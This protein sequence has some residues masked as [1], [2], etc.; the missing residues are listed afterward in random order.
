MT[1]PPTQD[2]LDAQFRA[3]IAS[4][5]ELAAWMALLQLEERAG[6]TLAL[7]RATFHRLV[8]RACQ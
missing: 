6:G 5:D 8:Q 3:A 7:Q 1:Q 4:R 2:D